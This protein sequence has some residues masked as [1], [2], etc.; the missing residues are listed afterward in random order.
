VSGDEEAISLPHLACD[1]AIRKVEALAV[2]A[3][4]TLLM[5]RPRTWN[6][7]RLGLSGPRV[8]G[9]SMILRMES[10]LLWTEG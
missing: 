1:V 6:Y 4:D 5:K 8:D 10:C 7:R 9:G 2:F 3:V